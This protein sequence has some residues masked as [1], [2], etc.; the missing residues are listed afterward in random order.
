MNS[1]VKITK[2]QS[3]INNGCGKLPKI[4]ELSAHFHKV[5]QRIISKIRSAMRNEGKAKISL[6]YCNIIIFFFLQDKNFL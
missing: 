2:L 5:K 4:I 1:N 6:E 3:S